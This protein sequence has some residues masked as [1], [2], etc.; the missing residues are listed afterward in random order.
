MTL[1]QLTSQLYP[2][3]QED[4]AVLLIALILR[5]KGVVHYTIWTGAKA[6][7]KASSGVLKKAREPEVN[8]MI[9]VM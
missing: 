3:I 6:R 7:R 9:M 4:I 1:C 2:S 8:M 5:Y